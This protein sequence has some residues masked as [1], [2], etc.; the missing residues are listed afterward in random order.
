MI[1]EVWHDPKNGLLPLNP[2]TKGGVEIWV[3]TSPT[4][5]GQS[6]WVTWQ[7]FDNAGNLIPDEMSTQ[8]D[9][10]NPRNPIH[11]ARCNWRKNESGK[12]YWCAK[13]DS[14]SNNA[15]RV[16]YNVLARQGKNVLTISSPDF[17]EFDIV[18]DYPAPS[19]SQPMGTAWTSGAKEGVCT[20]YSDQMSHVWFS[21]SKGTINEIYYPQLDNPNVKDFQFLVLDKNGHFNDPKQMDS[22]VG[23]LDVAMNLSSDDIPRSLGYRITNKDTRGNQ[24]QNRYELIM[25]AFAD[26]DEHTVMIGLKYVPKSDDAKQYRIFALFNPSINNGGKDDVSRFVTY[27]GIRMFLSWENGIYCALAANKPI[28]KSSCGFCGFNDGWTQL[29]QSK[30]LVN[31]YTSATNGDI[32]G[33]MEIDLPKDSFTATVTISFGQSEAEVLERAYRTVSKDITFVA[34]QFINQ[35]KEYIRSLED[36]GSLKAITINQSIENRKLAYVSTMC[37]KSMEDKIHKGAIIASMSI[38]WGD[39]KDGYYGG[40]HNSNAGGYHLVWG[41]DLY[42]M[43]TAAMAV[44]DFTTAVNIVRY[45]DTILQ[46]TNGSMPQNTWIDG[47]HYWG[48]EQLDETAYPIIIAWRLKKLGKLNSQELESFYNGLVTP[49]ADFLAGYNDTWT[50]D[51]WEEIIGRSPFTIATVVAGLVLAACWA[52]ERHQGEYSSRKWRDKA[53]D[54]AINDLND[55]YVNRMGKQY[56]ARI[57]NPWDGYY[58]KFMDVADA[59]FLELVRLGVS[60]PSSQRIRNSLNVVDAA[61]RTDI[62]GE[63]PY[64]LRYGRVDRQDAE[65]KDTYGEKDNGD[66]WTG[67]NSGRGRL[68]PLLSGERGHYE[69]INNNPDFA[70]RCIQAMTRSANKGYML[71]EQCWNGNAIEKDEHGHPLEYGKGT[72]SATPLGWTHGEYLKLLRSV[73]DGKVFDYIPEVA[74]FCKANGIYNM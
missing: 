40:Y 27:N 37:I 6:V 53:K 11:Y 22:S 30:D 12:S 49:A 8:I 72:K 63:F 2:T 64:F 35:W 9:P 71:P 3:G 13:I 62:Q 52:D 14:F 31:Q 68:W 29:K 15:V 21:H 41:R 57:F 18:P 48:N 70:K 28:L 58:S 17:F 34:L 73:S 39:C 38:P 20:A 1:T 50:Q 45:F 47:T 56:Y 59:G 44:G 24:G 25:D 10:G 55:C 16:I 5:M 19:P 36:L 61:I 54:F 74:D 23:Y 32:V 43:A 51:R 26:P 42:N 4:E 69:L 65:G 67:D 66:C 60:S 7:E 33:T 46:E